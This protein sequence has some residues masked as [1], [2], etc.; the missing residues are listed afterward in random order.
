MNQNKRRILVQYFLRTLKK[1]IES[2]SPETINPIFLNLFER[3]QLVKILKWLFIGK[4]PKE[5]DVE[6]MTN[7]E[8]LHAIGDDLHILSYC[9]EHW[10]KELEQKISPIEVN[11][12]LEQLGLES[13]YLNSKAIAFWDE[14]DYSNYNSLKA[15][16]GKEQPMYGIFDADVKEEDKYFI[17]TLPAKLYET[18]ELAEA[19]LNHLIA[20]GKF[21]K[22]ELKIMML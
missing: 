20:E 17:T 10:T 21:Q 6:K 8:I 5:Y 7:E 2:E 4:I 11:G 12:V 9:V 14:Y 13:H 15:K 18:E 22:G 3:D 16:A 1:K 19:E